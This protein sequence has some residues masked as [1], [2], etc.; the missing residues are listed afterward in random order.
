MAHLVGEKKWIYTFF[1]EVMP[2]LCHPIQPPQC[3]ELLPASLLR[4]LLPFRSP[5]RSFEAPQAL[6]KT[7]FLTIGNCRRGMTHKEGAA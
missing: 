1:C 7:S 5:V 6:G 2:P 4:Y 3:C